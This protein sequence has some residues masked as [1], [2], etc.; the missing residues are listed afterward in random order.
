MLKLED[1]KVYELGMEIGNL[2]WL[3]VR[4]WDYFSRDTLGKQIVRSADSIALNI[5]EGYGRFSYAE[6][7]VFLYYSRGSAFETRTSLS[8]AKERTLISDSEYMLLILKLD[9]FVFSLN[10]YI[11]SINILKTKS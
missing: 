7:R 10:S 4:M 5:S 8:K 2:V 1:L 11:K 6:K 3:K 9:Q